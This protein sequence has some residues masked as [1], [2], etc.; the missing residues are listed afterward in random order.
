MDGLQVR[1]IGVEWGGDEVG[2]KMWQL[3]LR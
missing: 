2:G 1:E 3:T